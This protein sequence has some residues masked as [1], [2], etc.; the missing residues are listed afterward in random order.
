MRK[1]LIAVVVLIILTPLF[2]YAAELV[3][4]SE[5]LENVAAALGVEEGEPLYGGILPDYKVSGL[6]PY[7]GTLISA[8]VGC[9]AV[10]L[11]VYSVSRLMRG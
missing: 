2:A 6:D 1:A 7:V 3:G 5:P 9:A 4:Y 11:L 10:F 8:A